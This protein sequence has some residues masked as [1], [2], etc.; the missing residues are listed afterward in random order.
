MQLLGACR[1]DSSLAAAYSSLQAARSGVPSTEALIAY[2]SQQLLEQFPTGLLADLRL[3][4]DHASAS[5][6]STYYEQLL[7]YYTAVRR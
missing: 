3:L 4:S 1:V 2:R 5:D 6:A 7:A